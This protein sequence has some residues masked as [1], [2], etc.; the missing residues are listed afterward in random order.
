MYP[1][2]Q[3]TR[4]VRERDCQ[5]RICRGER[6]ADAKNVLDLM[7]LG[8]EMGTVLEIHTEGPDASRTLQ[9]VVALFANNFDPDRA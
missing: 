6:V 1:C 3:I 2:S 8:A 9:E 5:V 7:S 4:L